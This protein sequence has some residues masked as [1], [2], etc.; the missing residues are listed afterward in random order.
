MTLSSI[1]LK[2]L[3][4]VLAT[5]LVG[6]SAVTLLA[7]PDAGNEDTRDAAGP[8][9]RRFATGTPRSLAPRAGNR[10]ATSVRPAASSTGHAET[11][12]AA[13]AARSVAGVPGL[14]GTSTS[15]TAALA[16]SAR[17]AKAKKHAAPAGPVTAAEVADLRKR[18]A[19]ADAKDKAA[20]LREIRDRRVSDLGPEVKALLDA[21]EA[22]E[23]RR[24]ATQILALGDAQA[25][26]S[27]LE[28]LKKDKDPVVRINAAFGLAR[29]GDDQAQ[30]WLLRLST[31]SGPL[32]P[33]L[34]PLVESMLES[35]D[36]TA[37]AVL[38]RYRRLAADPRLD[39]AKR[40]KAAAILATKL[41]PR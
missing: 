28:G 12:R 10:P 2:P 22:P 27:D 35:P 41:A 37:P 13:I 32:A 23:T 5:L 36:L 8:G 9:A 1:A 18:L 6:G 14:A 15:G 39:P 34:A 7:R 31:A 17:T 38:D 4:A 19:N 16:S 21:K 25:S 24:L 40:E 33:K 30:A 20:S 11:A 26:R 29:T 3:G